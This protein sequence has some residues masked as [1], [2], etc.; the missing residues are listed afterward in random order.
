MGAAVI[1]PEDQRLLFG[2]AIGLVLSSPFWFAVY[3]A[4]RWFGLPR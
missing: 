1:S 3:L 2:C 4:W